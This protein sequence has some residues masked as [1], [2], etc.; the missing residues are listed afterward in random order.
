MNEL[1]CDNICDFRVSCPRSVV[2][3]VLAGDKSSV[4]GADKSEKNIIFLDNIFCNICQL[5]TIPFRPTDSRIALDS[6][7]NPADI[8]GRNT[9]ERTSQMDGGIG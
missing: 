9:G 6:I 2:R 5:F 4:L 8:A 1:I 7:G 3:T